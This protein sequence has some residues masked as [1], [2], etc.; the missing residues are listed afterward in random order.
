MGENVAV[1]SSGVID[2]IETSFQKVYLNLYQ[3]ILFFLGRSSHCSTP[4]QIKG[5][6]LVLAICPAEKGILQKRQMPSD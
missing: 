4:V 2:M 1:V 6:F 3:L 5:D